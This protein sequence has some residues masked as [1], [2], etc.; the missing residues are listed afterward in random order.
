MALDSLSVDQLKKYALLMDAV[1]GSK[2]LCCKI[3]AHLDARAG[4]ALAPA[5]VEEWNR[6][7]R[8]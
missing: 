6:E 2:D 5:Y 3:L 8:A 1:Y 4:G 7:L